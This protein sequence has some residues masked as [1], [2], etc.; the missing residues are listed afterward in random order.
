MYTSIRALTVGLF[1]IGCLAAVAE[2]TPPIDVMK[3][4]NGALSVTLRGNS[5]S[6]RILSGLDSLFHLD[7][8][9]DFDAFDPDTPGASAGLNFEHIISGC[10]NSNNK[11]TPRS[12]NYRLVRDSD[13]KSGTLVR[14]SKD[15]PW[16]M[17]STLTYHVVDPHYIDFEF[18]CTPRDASLFG[19]HGYALLFFANYMNDVSNVALHFRGR[20]AKDTT[21]RWVEAAAPPGHVDWNQGG[22]YRSFLADELAIDDNV[23]FRLNTWSYDWP[24]ISKPFYFGRSERGMAFV[25]MFDRLYSARDQIRFSLFKFKVPKHPRP[26]WDFQYVIN[27]VQTD[28]TYGFRGRMVWKPFVSAEDCEDEYKQWRQVTREERI[29]ELRKRGAS[30]FSRG[31][32]VVEVN[33]NGTNLTDYELGWLADYE[34]MTDLS[35]EGV[36]ISDVGIA[37]LVSLKKLEWLNL[38][39]CP[40]GNATLRHLKSLP[41]L[42]HLPIGNSRVTDAGLVHVAAMPQLVYLGLRGN[43]ISDDGLHQIANLKELKGLHLGETDVTDSGLRNLVGLQK[44]ESL[45]LD[46]TEVSDKGLDTLVE[47]KGLRELHLK[48]TEVSK[49]GIQRLKKKIPRCVINQDNASSLRN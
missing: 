47:L 45:W 30:V 49:Q 8:T 14:R 36:A 18:S 17:D 24:R 21:D 23:E 37:Q 11:F 9:P 25:L 12:G 29:R 26:A 43:R 19:K 10:K 32:K 27:Q 16:K 40:V 3:V 28:Q 33:A 2:E 1:S 39:Q 15:S 48:N 22:T 5:Q 42:Q 7:K 41:Q 31:K 4:R 46:H 13:G 35:L 44:L 20:T 6:P 38:Y 34:E